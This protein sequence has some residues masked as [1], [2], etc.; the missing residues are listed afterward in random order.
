MASIEYVPMTLDNAYSA[1]TINDTTIPDEE[2]VVAYYAVTSQLACYSYQDNAFKIIASARNSRL[3][4]FVFAIRISLN[5][6]NVALLRGQAS[7]SSGVQSPSEVEVPSTAVSS[8]GTLVGSTTD[9]E[10]KEPSDEGIDTPKE[11]A[12]DSE[13]V[14]DASMASPTPSSQDSYTGSSSNES[15]EDSDLSVTMDG[16]DWDTRDEVWYC[17]SCNEDIVEGR[18]AQGHCGF[19]KSC[20][21]QYTGNNCPR[22]PDICQSCGHTKPDFLG[23]CAECGPVQD[24]NEEDYGMNFDAIDDVWRCSDCKWEVEADNDI[25]GYCACVDEDGQELRFDLLEYPEFYPADECSSD[26]DSSAEEPD[27]EDEAMIDDD[28]IAM[29]KSPFD[30]IQE[31]VQSEANSMNTMT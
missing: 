27:T 17:L 31:S 29:P 2:V 26:E 18:C 28:P 24:S 15:S 25:S 21:W 23:D 7:N 8:S 4:R 1:L 9:E 11:S 16:L 19:C 22:C 14:N 12:S 30:N 10:V 13:S 6:E 20:E 3:L 5:A